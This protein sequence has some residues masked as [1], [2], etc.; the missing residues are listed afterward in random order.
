MMS[1]CSSRLSTA[2]S[3]KRLLIAIP[4]LLWCPHSLLLSE[5]RGKAAAVWI[6]PPLPSKYCRHLN[7]WSYT[8]IL[9]CVFM[10]W[11]DKTFPLP[12]NRNWERIC[13]R[14]KASYNI[15]LPCSEQR[16]KKP[17]AVRKRLGL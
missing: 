7:W 12:E 14:I 2:S 4:V 5:H 15:Y 8:S 11:T 10:A 13:R 1:V 9:L 3:C 6:W 16:Q 17:P